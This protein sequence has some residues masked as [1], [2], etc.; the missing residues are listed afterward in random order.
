MVVSLPDGP[1]AQI[2]KSI[3]LKIAAVLNDDVDDDDDD[4]VAR[5]FDN[6]HIALFI[7]KWFAIAIYCG[8]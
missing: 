7:C 2:Y 1:H 8:D 6:H 5:K 3:A 4:E